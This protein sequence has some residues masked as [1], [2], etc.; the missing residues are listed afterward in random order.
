MLKTLANL[1]HLVSK[2][3]K[4]KVYANFLIITLSIYSFTILG[5]GLVQVLIC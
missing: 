3:P 5:A 2:Y 1:F 4:K